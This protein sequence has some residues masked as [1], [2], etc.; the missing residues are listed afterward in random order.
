MIPAPA[1][2]A[3]RRVLGDAGLWLHDAV[4]VEGAKLTATL[5]PADAGALGAALAVLGEHGLAALVRG[6]GTRLACA[7]PLRRADVLLDTTGLCAA[8]ELDADEGVMRAEAGSRLAALVEAAAGAGFELPLDPPGVEST[9]GGALASACPGPRFAAPRDAVL[10]L[11]VVLAGGERTRCGGRVV[12]NVTG[13]DLMK[14]HT[15][16]FGSLG[17][18]AAA[19]LRL[20]PRAERAATRVTHVSADARGF[21][22]ALAAARLPTARVAA[23]AAAGLARELAPGL[24]GPEGDDALLLAVEL[25]GDAAAVEA[26]AAR[27]AAW[28]GAVAGPEDL[29]ARLRRAQGAPAPEEGVRA[30]L[31]VLPARL[32]SAWRHAAAAGFAL[33]AHPARGL[34]YASRRG[35]AG[36]ALQEAHDAA[37]AAGA[38]LRVESAPLGVREAWAAAGG[39]VFELAPERLA[40]HRSLKQRFDPAATLNPGRFAGHL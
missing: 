27:L 3:L 18:I 20:R 22:D 6:G 15:G 23:L 28:L 34:L 5:R 39:D 19:W 31:A 37:R 29:V 36:A 12:K 24:A 35:E 2:R 9:L 33:L 14:L 10:G 30:R 38:A 25:A 7:N 21:A 11:D 26:D 32:G 13:Y 40:L 1:E 16:A 4:Q 8:P 17:V